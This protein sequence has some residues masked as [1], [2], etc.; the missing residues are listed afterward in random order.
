MKGNNSQYFCLIQ[1]KT[2]NLC[3]VNEGTT[4]AADISMYSVFT[5]RKDQKCNPTIIV[6]RKCK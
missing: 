6:F 2:K 1:N 5:F 4:V 3:D